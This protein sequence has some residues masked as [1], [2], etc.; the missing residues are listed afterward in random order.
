MEKE[1]IRKKKG[2]FWIP[3]T[4]QLFNIQIEVVGGETKGIN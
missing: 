1:R 4:A 2:A 3:Y